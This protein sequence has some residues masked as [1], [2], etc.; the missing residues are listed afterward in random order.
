M[1]VFEKKLCAYYLYLKILLWFLC[2]LETDA[3][4]T[5]VYVHVPSFVKYMKE[6]NAYKILVCSLMKRGYLNQVNMRGLG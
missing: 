5:V 4:A 3:V 2:F 6:T 1:K